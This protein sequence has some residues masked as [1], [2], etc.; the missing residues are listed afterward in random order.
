M[1]CTSGLKCSYSLENYFQRHF[2]H[3]FMKPQINLVQKRTPV[4]RFPYHFWS[5]NRVKL[6]IKPYGEN[7]KIPFSKLFK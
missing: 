2:S 7:T 3:T 1:A 6:N 5:K 4:Q